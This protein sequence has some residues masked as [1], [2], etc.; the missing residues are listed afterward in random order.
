MYITVLIPLAVVILFISYV[1]NVSFRLSEE[2]KFY[3]GN[4]TQ[5]TKVYTFTLNLN[6]LVGLKTLL[7]ALQEAFHVVNSN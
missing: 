7:S 2:P 3:T 6:K 5:M 1:I 4:A